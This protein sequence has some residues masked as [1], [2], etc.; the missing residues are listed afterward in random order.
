MHRLAI[1]LDMNATVDYY[2]V[3]DIVGAYPIHTNSKAYKQAYIRYDFDFFCLL[4][5]L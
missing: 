2:S 3:E 5:V 1:D 4:A